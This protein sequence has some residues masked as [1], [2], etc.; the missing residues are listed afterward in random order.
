MTGTTVWDDVVTVLSA[1][2][3][4]LRPVVVPR[5]GMNRTST[6]TAPRAARR[7]IVHA[8]REEEKQRLR[9]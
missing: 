1:I 6:T 5:E 3:A 7:I 2:V 9:R 4:R 8:M